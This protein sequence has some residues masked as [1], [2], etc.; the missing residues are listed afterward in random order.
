MFNLKKLKVMKKLVLICNLF[1]VFLFACTPKEKDDNCLVLKAELKDKGI[2][3]NELFKSISLIPLELNDNSYIKQ[4]EELYLINDTLFVFDKALNCLHI[5]DGISGKHLNTIMKVGQEH[6]EYTQVYSIIV[7]SLDRTVK[8]L[9]P[10]CFINTYDFSGQFIERNNLPVPPKVYK[11]FVNFND[12]TYLMWGTAYPVSKEFGNI[13][14]MQ[15]KTNQILNSFWSSEGLEYMFILSPFWNYQD[16]F[17]F[18]TAIS[19]KVYQITNDGYFLDYKWDFGEYNIDS[20]RESEV[21]NVDDI[22]SNERAHKIIQEMLESDVLYRFNRKFENDKYYYAQIVFK[23]DNG[24]SPHVFYHKETGKSYYF[25]KTTEGLYFLT[26]LLTDDY[27]IGELLPGNADEL[28][29]NN[30]LN[31]EDR[32]KLKKIQFDDNPILIKLYF[33]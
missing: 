9:S 17:Y 12:S 13:I 33:K 4:I 6:E 8:F 30:L 18:S 2:S 20:F 3:Y 15:K 24:Q 11:S 7:D 28:L 14:L 31:E 25:F 10:F 22:Q 29:K 16:K 26:Y 23:N 32:I 19:N 27:L 5:F 21:I 1:I